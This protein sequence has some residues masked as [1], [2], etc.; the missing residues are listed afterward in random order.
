MFESDF[1]PKMRVEKEILQKLGP[2]VKE[3]FPE[4]E[5]TYEA[6]PHN[7]AYVMGAPDEE[8]FKDTDERVYYKDKHGAVLRLSLKPENNQWCL[9]ITHFHKRDAE[10]SNRL[11]KSIKREYKGG[12]IEVHL[13]ER[14][15][16]VNFG[17]EVH[18][19][20]PKILEGGDRL[21]R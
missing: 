20:G 15:K 10:R 1:S 13:K 12:K 17:K 11:R 6:V 4:C 16:E 9:Y 8:D 19:A 2:L 21:R 14:P 18:V 7:P 3:F 5:A